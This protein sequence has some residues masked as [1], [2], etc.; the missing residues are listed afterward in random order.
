MTSYIRYI[1]ENIEPVRIAD[2]SMSQSGQTSTLRHIPGS[3]I[4]GLI[5]NK[6]AEKM[7][8]AEFDNI[9]TSFLSDSVRF[10]NAYLYADSY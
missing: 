5:I 6:L 4:R 7:T 3:S 9:K 1:I 10:L 8:E 2:D